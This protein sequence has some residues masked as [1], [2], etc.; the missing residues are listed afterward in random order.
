MI[1]ECLPNS[2]IAWFVFWIKLFCLWVPQRFMWLAGH[3]S[4]HD[5]H[6]LVGSKFDPFNRVFSRP[7]LMAKS[8]N[9]LT[10]TWGFD[11]ALTRAMTSISRASQTD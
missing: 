3:L 1:G 5:A 8:K 6:H 9:P 11:A 2:F 4:Q 10:E 7:A